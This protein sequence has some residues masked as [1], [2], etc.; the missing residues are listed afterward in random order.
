MKNHDHRMSSYY[1]YSSTSANISDDY[2]PPPAN[3]PA[4]VSKSLR[5]ISS[6]A[7]PT[8]SATGTTPTNVS[9]YDYYALRYNLR[10]KEDTI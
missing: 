3:R 7:T 2:A 4:E 8:S 5:N 9:S 10:T 1:D 6:S